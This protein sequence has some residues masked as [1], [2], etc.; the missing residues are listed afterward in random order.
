MFDASGAGV[1][2]PVQVDCIE[3]ISRSLSITTHP[4]AAPLGQRVLT[5]T[6]G[7]RKH[8]AYEPR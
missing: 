4:R 7:L 6:P 1:I 5:L 2:P 3:P 8:P